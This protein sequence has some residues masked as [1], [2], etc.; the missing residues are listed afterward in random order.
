M[1]IDIRKHIMSNFKDA[2]MDEVQTSITASIEENEE[3]TLP[4]L[5]VFFEILWKYS[6]E[7]SRQYILKTIT[8]HL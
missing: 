6:D 2:N 5:G 3:V 4:G 7:A 8:E 1:D